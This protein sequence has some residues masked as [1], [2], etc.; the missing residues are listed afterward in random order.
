MPDGN[1]TAFEIWIID[2]GHPGGIKISGQPENGITLQVV[3]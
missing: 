3:R 2:T 1:F